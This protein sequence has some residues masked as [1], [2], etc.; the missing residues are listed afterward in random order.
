MRGLWTLTWHENHEV[1]TGTPDASYVMVGGGHETGWLEFKYGY[2]NAESIRYHVEPSQHQWIK[3][4]A[5][6]VPVHF[7]LCGGD[8]WY[9]LAGTFHYLLVDAIKI[10]YLRHLSIAHG[11]QNE[12]RSRLSKALRELTNR[13]RA[14]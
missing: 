13:H 8:T 2:P 9:L 7:L 1:G 5:E 12:I 14:N 3:D 10:D 6:R 4:H 11:T